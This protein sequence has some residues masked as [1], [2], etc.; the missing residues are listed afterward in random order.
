MS[1]IFPES[2]N[3]IDG[4]TENLALKIH[5]DYIR[6]MV[7]RVDH[8]LGNLTKASGEATI[9]QIIQQ[10]VE[11]EGDTANLSSEVS[12]VEGQINTINTNLNNKVD[13]VTGKGLSTNDYTNADKN[14]VD[15]VTSALNGKV[16]KEQ[17]KGLSTNDFT[18]ALKDKLTD[19]EGIFSIGQGLSL[20]QLGELVASGAGFRV[21]TQADYTA[22]QAEYD[23]S[24]DVFVISDSGIAN[25][26]A[27]VT[28]DNTGTQVAANTVQ[29]AITE[30]DGD[31]TALK[32]N[33]VQLWSN[34]QDTFAPQTVPLDL[35]GY[36]FVIITFGFTSHIPSYSQMF[37]IAGIAAFLSVFGILPDTPTSAFTTIN[38][39]S[40]S[41]TVSS[42]GVAFGKGQMLYNGA[43]YADWNDRCVPS[44][45]YGVK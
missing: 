8:S 44:A 21:V 25:S 13:K 43:Y 35:S 23:A 40:R 15:G 26:A 32:N 3:R 38:A 41:I 2:M 12:V 33:L 7:E 28:Y 24:D 18:T 6:Y 45:I 27:N 30:I 20:S 1:K 29:G 10:L 5:D 39:C 9:E 42:T 11:L 31:I 34:S 14:I 16:D 19:L 36:R 22:H 4:L 37:P 17:G